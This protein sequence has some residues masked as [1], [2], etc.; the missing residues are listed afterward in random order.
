MAASGLR[1]G[2]PIG[3]GDLWV[4]VEGLG[5]LWCQS[6]ERRTWRSGS[7]AEEAD[8]A[9]RFPTRRGGPGGVVPYQERRTRRSGS[10]PGEVDLAEWGHARREGRGE[11]VL[12][13]KRAGLWLLAVKAEGMGQASTRM[14]TSSRQF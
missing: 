13:Q 9:Q 4:L 11:V 7:L 8:P 12:Y 14:G 6:Q 2:D 5:W 1:T 3:A 10:L